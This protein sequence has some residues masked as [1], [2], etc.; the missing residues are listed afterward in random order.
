M[1]LLKKVPQALP[2]NDGFEYVGACQ[3]PTKWAAFKLH[4]FVEHATGK[5]HL[6]LTLGDVATGKPVL[7]RVHSECLT[8]DVA[9]SRQ[10]AQ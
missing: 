1:Q 8:G 7:A 10:A 3:L 4:A 9:D 6:A 2:A 5:E